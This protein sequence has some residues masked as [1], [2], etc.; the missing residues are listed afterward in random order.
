M[1]QKLPFVLLIIGV[2][3]LLAAFLV[4]RGR[5]ASDAGEDNVPELPLSQRPY[6]RLV[7]TEDG[8]YLNMIVSNFKVPG[9]VSMDYE[10]Y[11]DTAEGITQGVPGKINLDGKQSVERQ[12]LL[13]SESSGKYRY[14]EGVD[15]GTLTLR[16]R[17]ADGKLIG[18]VAG[19]WSFVTDTTELASLDG[20]FKY[21]LEKEAKGV[22]FVIMPTFGVP[23]DATGEVVSGPYGIF[24]SEGGP[25][26]GS[27]DLNGNV[28]AW[29]GS[30]WQS[31]S[32]SS[33]DLGVFIAT[34]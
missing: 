3:V 22:Y 27:V 17:D 5:G 9:A 30:N 33:D 4:L 20:K 6:T 21:T 10:L 1:K 23:Q 31:V 12:L 28:Y 19:Q 13:G 2:L 32:G 25:F 29:Y 26:A 14:D 18:K 7:P 8:H 15:D 16:F 24:A 34:N 11:Y